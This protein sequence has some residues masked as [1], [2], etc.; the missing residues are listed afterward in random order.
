M[1]SV[2]QLTK[3]IVVRD[4][5]GIEQHKRETLE[6]RRRLAR[7]SHRARQRARLTHSIP[8]WAD[9]KAIAAVYALADSYTRRRGKPY[10]VD[11]I[12]PLR[13]KNVCGLHVA[14]NLRVILK[15]D[16]RKKSNHFHEEMVGGT[17]IEPVTST[18]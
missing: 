4:E 15:E 8:P 5:A 12:V 3:L 2:I 17:G 11:H 14:N 6:S 18:V 13:G 1:G 16:N 10:E 7:K 9:M